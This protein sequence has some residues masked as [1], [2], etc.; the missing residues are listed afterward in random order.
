MDGPRGAPAGTSAP[1]DGEWTQGGNGPAAHSPQKQEEEEEDCFQCKL[2]GAMTFSF[3]AGKML[4]DSYL[5]P[6]EAP[7]RRVRRSLPCR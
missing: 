5:A 6:G 4:H 1:R 2:M 7:A 3:L